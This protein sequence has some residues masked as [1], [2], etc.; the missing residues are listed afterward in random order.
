MTECVVA[1]Y[2]AVCRGPEENRAKTESYLPARLEATI[3]V[4][5][6]LER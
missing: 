6:R 1:L 2:E 5:S 4:W 3:E